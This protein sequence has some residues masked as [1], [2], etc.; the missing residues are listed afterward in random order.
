[1]VQNEGKMDPLNYVYLAV[2]PKQASATLAI[3]C[4]SYR[5]VNHSLY[6]LTYYNLTVWQMAVHF[7]VNTDVC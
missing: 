7:N 2:L 3:S 5:N 6:T 4:S 1:M